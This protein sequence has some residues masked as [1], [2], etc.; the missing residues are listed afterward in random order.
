VHWASLTALVTG[1]E[2]GVRRMDEQVSVRSAPD[3]DAPAKNLAWI[4]RVNE[5]FSPQI[6]K[7]F[8]GLLS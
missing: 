8:K 2:R 6:I 7:T 3:P 4:Q 5:K 1:P